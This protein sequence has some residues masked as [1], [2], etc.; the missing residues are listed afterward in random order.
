MKDFL[1]EMETIQ[2]NSR[3]N[4]F[5]QQD[6][7]ICLDPFL[8]GKFIKRIP[9][10]RHYFHAECINKWFESKI[11]EHEQK[12]P[13]CNMALVTKEMQR[14]KLENMALDHTCEL[15]FYDQNFGSLDN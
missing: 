5:N 6:C 1:M 13:Q 7:I 14:A 8:I 3:N 4:E 2:F 15:D 10:C 11:S 12:C 9:I